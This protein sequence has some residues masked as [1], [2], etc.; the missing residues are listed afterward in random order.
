[1]NKIIRSMTEMKKEL[2]LNVAV[3]KDSNI[4]STVTYDEKMIA[5]FENEHEYLTA[6]MEAYVEMCEER[7]NHT[8]S[9]ISDI[10]LYNTPASKVSKLRTT[11][12]ENYYTFN[13]LLGLYKDA[14][15]EKVT[16]PRSENNKVIPL[17]ES[18]S[19]EIDDILLN[20]DQEA[21]AEAYR[22]T[23]KRKWNKYK[24]VVEDNVVAYA[25]SGTFDSYKHGPSTLYIEKEMGQVKSYWES[26]ANLYNKDQ[27]NIN[28]ATDEFLKVLDNYRF[29]VNNWVK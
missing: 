23:P 2:D 19:N 24:E 13:A 14:P 25:E 18:L 28:D 20:Y 29:R 17:M 6:L 1:M 22:N 9:C 3:L 4:K 21:V 12:G 8:N 16:L 15:I 10:V 11:L 27:K 7:A 26:Y 5:G